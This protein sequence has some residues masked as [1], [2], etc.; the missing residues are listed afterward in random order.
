MSD[1]NLEVLDPYQL[2]QNYKTFPSFST[3]AIT[4]FSDTRWNRY[5]ET[6]NERK[7]ASPALLAEAQEVVKR[8]T[9]VDTG[10]IEGL[11][12]TDRGFTFTI[13]VEAAMWQAKAESIKGSYV[14]ALIESQVEAYNYVLN[15][16][17]QEVP[18]SEA[19]I[20]TLHEIVCGSQET[21]SAYTEMG[22]QKQPL[23]KGRYKIFSNHVRRKNGGTHSYA[24]VDLTSD[25]MYKLCR[26]LRS[27]KFLNAHP[28]LQASYAHYAFVVIH[29]FA[30]GNGRVARALGSVFTYR[31]QSVPLLILAEKRHQYLKTLEAA[32]KEEYS[33]FV[34]FILD[35][36][37][38]SMQ[39]VE[40][41]IKAAS[42]PHLSFLLPSFERFDK[43]KSG[44]TQF[45][46]DDASNELI[47]LIYEEMNTFIE[48]SL[49]S[50]QSK[51]IVTAQ[52][53]NLGGLGSPIKTYRT[54]KATGNSSV[55]AITLRADTPQLY[56]NFSSSGLFYIVVPANGGSDDDI[57]LISSNYQKNNLTEKDATFNVRI[58]DVLPR[59]STAVQMRVR[60]LAQRVVGELANELYTNINK[61]ANRSF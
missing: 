59:I 42:V 51:I 44:Y 9:A 3:W 11:Y 28:V 27:N 20:R 38:D 56:E 16:A 53:I 33:P 8:A 47:K 50:T 15:L 29:P 2:D 60:M 24:P 55:P 23:I 43:T 54:V 18:I 17:T 35:S 61:K 31:A 1:E 46:I 30:D 34:H 52:L 40:E 21:Y 25:E 26:E 36:T 13:A 45:E 22:M 12:E 5:V 10:A 7:M 37:L 48:E 6:L 19:S 4:R 32:D 39:L 57:L 58:S 41:S 49:L 14:R